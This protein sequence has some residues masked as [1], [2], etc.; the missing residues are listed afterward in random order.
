MLQGFQNIILAIKDWAN[1]KFQPSG[2]YALVD[3]AGY[4]LGLNIDRDYVM[5]I[6]LKNASGNVLSAQSI[7]FPIESMVVNASYA[8]GELALTLQNGQTLTVDISSIVNGLVNDTF[9][10]AGINMK[11]NITKEELASA[12]G[13]PT[14]TSDLENDSNFLTDTG[15][16]SNTTVTFEQATQRAN[17]QS[18]DSLEVAF[19]KLS[20]YCA[21]LNAVAF[22]G[23]YGDLTGVPQSLKN[24]NALTFTGAVTG[25]Y[26]GSAE[27]SV[28]IPSI[29]NN[30]LATA[31][32]TALDAVQGKALDD[33]ITQIN[34]DMV[35]SGAFETW[36]YCHKI[37][38]FG[39]VLII[40]KTN[41][42]QRL[43]I[44]HI[45][46]FG[47]DAIWHECAIKSIR[48][49][50][51]HVKTQFLVIIDLLGEKFLTDGLSYLC[52]VR[53]NITNA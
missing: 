10:I 2:N 40:P 50:A 44:T 17:V 20:K 11:D 39:V 38:G 12:L 34:S 8:D 21:D 6:E 52:N 19:A 48:D 23:A 4:S 25:S 22:S 15:N 28:A 46:V 7:D 27:E 13:V 1:G 51:P 35:I 36:L 29:T 3:N 32:G 16:S 41:N 37:K 31:A 47:D 42:L 14:K 5:T 53:G 24:P 45:E 30:L 33:K 49:A 18:G 26:D 43:S 9:T